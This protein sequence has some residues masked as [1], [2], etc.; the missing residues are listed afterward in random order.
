[1]R[2]ACGVEYDGRAY[3]GW[4]RQKNSPSVQQVLETALSKVADR[5]VQTFC[6]GRTDAGVHATA[7]VVHFDTD[8]QRSQRSWLLGGNTN[9]PSDIAISWVQQVSDSFHARFKALERS[10]RYVVLNSHTRSALL[11][12]RASWWVKKVD[13]RKMQQAAEH[14][15]GEHD[16]SAYR[17]TACQAKTPVR[18]LHELD[19]QMCGDIIYID[20]RAD[21]FLHHM[22][23]NIVGVLLT[24]GSGEQPTDWSKSVLETRQRDRG[25]VTAPP[26]G[27]YLTDIRYP[28]GYKIPRMGYKPVF[29]RSLA[30]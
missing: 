26:D 13:L 5:P 15:I 12:K 6:A 2:I 30:K 29:G 21:G 28:D 23:R 18:V 19:I 25:G 24:I 11:Y 10:Y 3:H 16:F 14:L 1:M 20:A 27:L 9:L 17:A 8:V 22:V 7:Q 4:Q